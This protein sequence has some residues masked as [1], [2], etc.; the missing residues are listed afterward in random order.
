MTLAIVVN[1]VLGVVLLGLLALRSRPDTVILGAPDEAMTLFRRSFPDAVGRATLA[2]DGRGALIELDAG[3]GLGLLLRNGRRWNAR[4]LSARDLA[5]VRS[6]SQIL[7]IRFKDF[8]WP[9]ARLRFDD[10][11][12]RAAWSARIEELLAPPGASRREMRHA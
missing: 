7:E 8:A 3:G 12:A 1:L 9:R 5:S 2:S 10:A 4:L 11:A 6:A